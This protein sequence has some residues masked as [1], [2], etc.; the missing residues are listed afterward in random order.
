MLLVL[1]CVRMGG[2]AFRAPFFLKQ[3]LPETQAVRH[4]KAVPSL[5]APPNPIRILSPCLIRLA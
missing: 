5:Q 3:G 1:P 2:G 4:L